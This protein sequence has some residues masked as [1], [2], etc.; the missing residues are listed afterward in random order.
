MEKISWIKEYHED[1]GTKDKQGVYDYAY[2]Y[3]IYWFTLPNK[4]KIKV[5]RYTDT[6][7]HS[8]IFLPDEDL[9]IKKALD[10]LPSKN[11]IFGII[12]FLLKK[13]GV[14]T[15]DYYNMGYKSIDLKNVKNNFNE[16]NFEEAKGG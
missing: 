10:K 5:R 2:R 4:Q 6:P 1:L 14:K 7:D 15:I 13:E 11:Y 16:F 8:S 9:A 3:Y 12:H